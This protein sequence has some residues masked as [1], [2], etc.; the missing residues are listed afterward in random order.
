MGTIRSP[1]GTMWTYFSS[2]CFQLP[3]WPSETHQFYSKWCRWLLSAV[4]RLM[5]KIG[6]SSKSRS[7]SEF[8]YLQS[9]KNSMLCSIF[10]SPIINKNDLNAIIGATCLRSHSSIFS[11]CVENAWATKS[12]EKWIFS[13]LSFAEISV[14]KMRFCV[15]WNKCF[16]WKP[17]RENRSSNKVNV[18]SE[19]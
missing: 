3:A 9:G 16:I 1:S 18:R 6:V 14:Y 10:N 13:C 12:V 5:A 15:L 19:W 4:K 17:W 7:D 2:C 11:A 8:R